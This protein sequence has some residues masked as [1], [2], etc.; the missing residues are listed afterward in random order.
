MLTIINDPDNVNQNQNEKHLT[1]P[2]RMAVTKRTK[3]RCRE[4][5]KLVGIGMEIGSTL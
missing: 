3:F 2:V 4:K 1:T 5:A